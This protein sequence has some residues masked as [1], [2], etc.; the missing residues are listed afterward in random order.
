M[1]AL[2]NHEFKTTNILFPFKMSNIS[3]TF[4]S[5][6]PGRSTANNSSF[7]VNSTNFILLAIQCVRISES[8]KSTY[9]Y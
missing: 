1:N 4:K 2:Q 6:F 9:A 7:I 8:P 3:V 5:P